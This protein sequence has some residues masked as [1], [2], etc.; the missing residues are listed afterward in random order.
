MS[1]CGPSQSSSCCAPPAT[2]KACCAPE[3]EAKAQT[4]CAPKTESK[5]QSCSSQCCALADNENIKSQVRTTYGQ[6]ATT[7]VTNAD[8]VAK[9][10]GYSKE[11]LDAIPEGA[12]MGLSCGNPLAHASI[13]E[14]EVVV[15][16]G[17]GGGLDCFLASPKVGPSGKI[18]GIDMTPEM[19]AL[20][21]SNAIKRN[22]TNV[23]FIQG[24][25]ESLPLPDNVADVVISNCVINLVPNKQKAFSEI[26][27]VL[28]PGGRLA[29]SDIVL[30]KAIPDH[31]KSNI[32]LLCACIGGGSLISEVP[33]QLQSAGFQGVLVHDTKADL[34]AYKALGSGGCCASLNPLVSE[35]DLNVDFNEY[36]T[37]AK[38]F[39]YK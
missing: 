7:A 28:K 17:S 19:I 30:K 10:F 16:L 25:I 24:E 2:T 1:C 8:E 38:I 26:F 34:N 11:E 36:A 12:N 23:E 33:Q 31:L 37:S 20:A 9:K 18:Y 39:A 27:R 5:A 35:S 13:K 14:G 15:D 3:K 21:K 22:I 32:D 4:C 29:I 6:V